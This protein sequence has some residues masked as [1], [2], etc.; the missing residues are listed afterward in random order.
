MRAAAALA[1]SFVGIGAAQAAPFPAAW[2]PRHGE[3]Y[4]I[5]DT[6]AERGLRYGR[7]ELIGLIER[8]AERVAAEQPGAMLYVGDLSLKTGGLTQ[9]HRSHRRGTDADL[10]FFAVDDDG[11]PASPPT[12]MVPFGADG[13]ARLPDGKVVHFDT[14]R[15]WELVK[16]LLLD[17]ETR[18]ANIFISSELRAALLQYAA[19][20]GEPADL[21]ARASDVLGQPGDS[22]AHDDHMHVRIAVIADAAPAPVVRARAGARES[23]A[24]VARN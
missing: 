1:V 12:E 8:V 9:W 7:P 17:E 6:W 18:V 2:L 10:L 21:V 23:K 13:T 16:A 24:A 14:P 22:K 5:P 11:E 19:E 20:A 4:L 3:G 15:N